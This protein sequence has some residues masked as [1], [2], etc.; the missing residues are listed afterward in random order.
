MRL[1]CANETKDQMRSFTCGFSLFS[2]QNLKPQEQRTDKADR[3]SERTALLQP[4]AGHHLI[5]G[6][7]EERES[8]HLGTQRKTNAIS[9][10]S[11]KFLAIN[12]L[13]LR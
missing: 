7:S 9:L 13:Y 3:I 6:L 10:P 11:T 4:F 12:C 1:I 5:L 2:Y 8:T